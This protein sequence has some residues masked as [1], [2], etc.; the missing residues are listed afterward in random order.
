MGE[1]LSLKSYLGLCRDYKNRDALSK[2]FS[3]SHLVEECNEEPF[4]M[5]SFSSLLYL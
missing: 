1:Y 5:S 2:Y 3:P 4:L